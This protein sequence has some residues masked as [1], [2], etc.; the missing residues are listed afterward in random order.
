MKKLFRISIGLAILSMLAVNAH[1]DSFIGLGSAGSFV[2]LGAAAVTNTGAT[3]LGGNLGVSPGTSI[4]GSGSITLTGVIHQTDGV[5]ALAQFDAN[6]AFISMGNQV[7]TG[8]L[9]PQL[10]GQTIGV[11][12]WDLGSANLSVGGVLTLDFG[13][14]SNQNI[15]L[16][17][18]ALTAVSGSTV[19]VLGSGTNNNVY[20]QIGSS[21]TIGTGVSFVGNIIALTSVSVQTSA[22]I[23][24]GSVIALNALVSL[25]N[26]T[27]SKTCAIATSSNVLAGSTGTGTTGGTPPG[28][29]TAVIPPGQTTTVKVPEGGSSLLY[30]LA[31][32]VSL[33]AFIAF[34]RSI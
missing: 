10:N 18:S 33:G 5:A 12:V 16:R 7:A 27:I 4:T 15:I 8:S 26:N 25:D 30:M 6:N 28:T 17:A 1:A 32:L 3:T 24:C 23:G 34:R 22:K 19:K 21:A 2:V 31:S 9:A 20:W 14:A 11:G 29:T 13:S